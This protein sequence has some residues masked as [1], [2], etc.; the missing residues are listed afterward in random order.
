MLARLALCPRSDQSHPS[1][2]GFG[3]EDPTA[4]ET[5]MTSMTKTATRPNVATRSIDLPEFVL[6]TNADGITTLTLNR[7][8][9]RN[10]L[11]EAMIDALQSALDEAATD[12]ATRVIVIAGN[13]PVFSSGHDLKELAAHRK[14]EDGG[15]GYFAM[16]MEKCSRMMISVVRCPKPL[17]A[18]IDGT[19]AAAGC[20]LVASCDLAVASKASSFCTPGVNIGLFC[21]T[22]M[23]ALS[24]NVARKHAMAMLL[25]GEM[26]SAKRA[27]RIGLVNEV[28]KPARVAARTRELALRI[29]SKSAL[30]LAIGKEAFYRQAEMPL[31]DAYRY[32]SEVMVRNMMARDA[33]EGIGAF[34]EKRDPQWKDL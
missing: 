16:I 17:I 24:R 21:S 20:Q 29:A 1:A 4:A 3:A 25:T 14:D 6:R 23:V 12:E 28:V 22:P 11:S 19:A 18:Q 32:A 34:I 30:T 26:I 2:L 7:S 5:G 8:D 33:D 15:R 27:K 9:V 31:D 10:C 13:G